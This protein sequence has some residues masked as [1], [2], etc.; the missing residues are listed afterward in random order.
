MMLTIGENIVT[1]PRIAYSVPQAFM[2]SAPL[3]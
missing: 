3:N 2:Y 1:C